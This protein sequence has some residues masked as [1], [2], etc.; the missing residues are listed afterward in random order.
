MW[1]FDLYYNLFEPSVGGS[2][3]AC[4]YLPRRI[5]TPK[6]PIRRWRVKKFAALEEEEKVTSK[7]KVAAAKK[8][9]D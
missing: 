7:T 5:H 3:F 1:H 8:V 2:R 9:T 6:Q 4:V